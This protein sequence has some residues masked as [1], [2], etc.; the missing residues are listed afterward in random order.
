MTSRPC[1]YSR[2][3]PKTRVLHVRV[4][5]TE[6]A[7]WRVSAAARGRTPSELVHELLGGAAADGVTP[8]GEGTGSWLSPQPQPAR[9]KAP[10]TLEER[11]AAIG[12]LVDGLG[13][14]GPLPHPGEGEAVSEAA[15]AL[16][17]RLTA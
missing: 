13:V 12:E 1:P 5:P 14:A 4:D 6:L 7:V 10:A 17:R 8:R 3:V 15:S 16:E 11:L 9:A 2:L